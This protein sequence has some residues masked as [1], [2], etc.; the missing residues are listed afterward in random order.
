MIHNFHICVYRTSIVNRMQTCY[1]RTFTVGCTVPELELKE[2]ITVCVQSHNMLRF[3]PGVTSGHSPHPPNTQQRFP[4][5]LTFKTPPNLRESINPSKGVNYS[6]VVEILFSLFPDGEN[7]QDS[8]PDRCRT[9]AVVGNSGNLEGSRYGPLIDAHDFVIRMNEGPTE[10]YEKDVGSKTTHRAIYPEILD[11]QWLI[12]IFTTKHIKRTYKPVKN[13]IR[14]NIDK[15]M[16]LHPEFIKYVYTK[17]LQKQGKY[18]STGFLMLVFSLHIC[19]QVNVFGFGARKDGRWH[20]YFDKRYGI[21]HNTPEHKGSYRPN[22]W[23][24]LLFFNAFSLFPCLFI[25]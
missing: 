9:C 4:H 21:F 11:L 25:L 10:G 18:P 16:I 24:H 14:A 5:S 12:S 20:H 13:T 2:H 3:C 19:D 8:G 17:W 23:T 15:V 1:T 6:E 7:L 22:V